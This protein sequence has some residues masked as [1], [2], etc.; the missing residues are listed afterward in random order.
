MKIFENK[1]SWFELE[2]TDNFKD[3]IKILPK[4]LPEYSA[5]E[6][7][8][9]ALTYL[10]MGEEVF[11]SINSGEDLICFYVRQRNAIGEME[12]KKLYSRNKSDAF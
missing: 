5:R 2:K 7:F 12:T 9:D 11:I 4:W 3:V 10:N 1:E 6:I 8:A